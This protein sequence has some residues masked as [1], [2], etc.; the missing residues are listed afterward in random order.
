MNAAALLRCSTVS[1]FLIAATLARSAPLYG[2]VELVEGATEIVDAKGQLRVPRAGDKVFEGETM[3]TGSDG[4]LHLKTSDHGLVALRSNTQI[5]VEVYRADGDAEDTSV[6]SL[7][8][9][10]LRT[11]SG[12]IGKYQPRRVMIKTTVATIGI[13]G[14]D[15]EP[16]YVAPG[17]KG[18]VP[19]GTYD[20]VNTGATYIET[21]AGRIEVEKGRAG[22]APHDGKTAPRVLDRIPEVY[23]PTRNEERIHKRKAELERELE[24]ARVERQ[25][26]KAKEMEE[27]TAGK[28]ESPKAESKSEAVK[29]EARKRA[30]ERKRHPLK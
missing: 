5:K 27:K 7:L 16:L 24:K 4:E 19:A 30:A 22:F 3:R 25:K 21:A 15:H 20:K 9:G 13:R 18:P 26:A 8:S 23:R 11:I 2:D 6:V 14:T 1:L 29:E 28:A 10:T 17:D 12:W